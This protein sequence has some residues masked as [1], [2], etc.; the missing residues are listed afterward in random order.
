MDGYVRSDSAGDERRHPAQSINNIEA[1]EQNMKSWMEVLG[2]A[3]I[4]TM[5]VAFGAF[6]L[7]NLAR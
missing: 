1:R 6:T 3:V 5:T 2:P 4:L 7:S